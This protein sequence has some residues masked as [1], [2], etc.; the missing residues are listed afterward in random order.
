MYKRQVDGNLIIQ[1]LQQ[2]IDNIRAMSRDEELVVRRVYNTL[3]PVSYTHLDVYKR[4]A[5]H[6][7]YEIGRNL[8]DKERQEVIARVRAKG[9]RVEDCLLYTSR[10]V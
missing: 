4:Q 5:L 10:C 9:Y 7:L 8:S 3:H 2:S 6:S 1:L